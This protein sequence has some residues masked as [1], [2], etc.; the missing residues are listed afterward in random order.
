MFCSFWWDA[1]CEVLL[2]CLIPRG[3]G[4]RRWELLEPWLS[5]CVGGPQEIPFYHIW[6]GSQRALHCTFTL[7]RYSQASSELT[8]KIC[9]RQVEG[10][11]Q[12]FQ[13]HVTLGE[14]S[15][16]ELGAQLGTRRD[17]SAMSHPVLP[18]PAWQLLRHPPLPPQ[19]CHHLRH[20]PG[21]TLRLQNPS[22][23]P[24]EDLQQP[25]CSQLQ[26][27]RLETSCPEAFHGPVGLPRPCFPF[28]CPQ[29]GGFILCYLSAVGIQRGC[30]QLYGSIHKW[31]Y[32]SA[33]LYPSLSL[34]MILNFKRGE[35]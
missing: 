24:A 17:I 12:I 14:V 7:E 34:D 23:H 21:G 30:V 16:G 35:V 18:L 27:E 6:S 11:G 9:V 33:Q 4:W 29:Q 13:L 22:L 5:P 28:L 2:P 19:R 32:S 15:R 20:H 25:G 26:G 3:G 31:G 10:E 1:L 8:C